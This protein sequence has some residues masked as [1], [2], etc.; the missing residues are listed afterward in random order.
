MKKQKAKLQT[1]YGK[2]KALPDKIRWS[3]YNTSKLYAY[4][5]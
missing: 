5:V 1:E 2:W 4:N 3:L